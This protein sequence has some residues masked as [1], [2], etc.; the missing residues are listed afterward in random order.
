MNKFRFTM[1][2]YVLGMHKCDSWQACTHCLTLVLNNYSSALQY[3]YVHT[4]CTSWFLGNES[5]LVC[6]PIIFWSWTS[7]SG[8][9]TSAD[10]MSNYSML[11]SIVLNVMNNLQLILQVLFRHEQT[12][13]GP[14]GPIQSRTIYSWLCRSCSVMDNLQLALQVLFCHEQFTVGPAGPVLP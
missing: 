5:S 2:S 1:N 8:P 9:Y 13:V 4:N 14:D 3:L 7:Y 10:V 6:H 11:T 12:T